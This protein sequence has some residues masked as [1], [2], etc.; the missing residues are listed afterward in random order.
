MS[1]NTISIFLLTI[2]I[3]GINCNSEKTTSTPSKVLPKKES[4][5]LITS[6]NSTIPLE[7]KTENDTYDELIGYWFTPHAATINI[8][9]F[10]DSHFILND[11]NTQIE[12]EEQLSGVYSLEAEKLTLNYN[13][14][15]SQSFRFYKGEENDGN[16]YIKN[17]GNYFVKGEI[18]S[19][20]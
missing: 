9:F 8:Q 18:P 10:E 12:Q 14:R 7:E 19:V 6:T 4:D 17:P 13:D 2:S 20:K 16:Y 15:P 5:S 11:Y 1:L 3:L